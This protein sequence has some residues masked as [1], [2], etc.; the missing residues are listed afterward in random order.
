MKKFT[1]KD[2]DNFEVIDGIKQC[3]SGDY[4]EI[5]RFAEGCSFAERCSF[6]DGCS[7][8]QAT[9]HLLHSRLSKLPDDLTLELMRRD[10]QFHPDPKLLDEWAKGGK[11]PYDNC[12]CQ[13]IYHFDINRELWRKGKPKMS[14]YELLVAIAKEKK[15][16]IG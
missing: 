12:I 3:P 2:F 15:W 1:Q 7:F 14:D 16:K 9:I 8:K 4:S 13:Q 11:C 10:A 5:K 6:A